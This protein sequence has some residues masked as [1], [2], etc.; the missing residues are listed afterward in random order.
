MDLIQSK[1]TEKHEVQIE[2]YAMKLNIKKKVFFE[3]FIAPTSD[4]I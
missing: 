2:D 3:E 4:I 1:L